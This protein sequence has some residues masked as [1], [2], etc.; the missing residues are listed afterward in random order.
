MVLTNLSGAPRSLRMSSSTTDANRPGL[1]GAEAGSRSDGPQ[2]WFAL[3]VRIRQAKPR[4][5]VGDDA[6]AIQPATGNP[7]LMHKRRV[8]TLPRC[9]DDVV[10]GHFVPTCPYVDPVGMKLK[11]PKFTTLAHL[12]RQSSRRLR[13]PGIIEYASPTWTG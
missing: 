12:S 13:H 4:H 10:D 3:H 1:L 5:D 2:S 11:P 9:A 7:A 8:E 6:R